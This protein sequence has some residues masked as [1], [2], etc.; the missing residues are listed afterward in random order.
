MNTA[1][2]PKKG[3]KTKPYSMDKT[4]KESSPINGNMEKGFKEMRPVYGIMNK[5]IKEM[6]PVY[7]ISMDKTLKGSSPINGNMEKGFKEMRPV[8]GI[9]NKGLKEMRPVYGIS[10]DKTLK[11]SSPI[12]GNMDRKNLK[13]LSKNQLIRLLLKQQSRNGVKHEDIIQPPEQFRDK[14]IP[15]PR[16]GKWKVVKPKKCKTNGK[17][18]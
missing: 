5:G 12:N 15:K 1:T 14:P 4:L 6:R 18:V 7:G 8:Y 11:E 16:I 3:L 17:R 13:K 9:M 10:M 2:L